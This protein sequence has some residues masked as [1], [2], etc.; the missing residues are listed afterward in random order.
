[1]LHE[2]FRHSQNKN[3]LCAHLTILFCLW[4][5]NLFCEF[6]S[7]NH[8]SDTVHTC[9]NHLGSNALI[10][11]GNKY[12]YCISDMHSSPDKKCPSRPDFSLAYKVSTA[13]SMSIIE[14]LVVYLASYGLLKKP[15]VKISEN[16]QSVSNLFHMF[17]DVI[18]CIV[19]ELVL[20]YQK[21]CSI[22]YNFPLW[23]IFKF[24]NL[25]LD[26]PAD[27]EI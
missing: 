21:T 6:R 4:C 16:E 24:G 14:Q 17:F 5:E 18:W 3:N 8:F 15:D 26:Q 27:D 25:N 19:V 22:I 2:L 1:M 13:L 20:C 7:W 11:S 10:R 12:F 23:P 9:P